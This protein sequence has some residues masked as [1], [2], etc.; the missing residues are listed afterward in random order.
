MVSAASLSNVIF[1]W[2]LRGGSAGGED[3]RLWCTLGVKY[4]HPNVNLLLFYDHVYAW[5]TRILYRLVHSHYLNVVS[6]LIGMAWFGVRTITTTRN[7][8]CVVFWL[9]SCLDSANRRGGRT[10]YQIWA[11]LTREN[12]F[13]N[14]KKQ[15][16]EA[17]FHRCLVPNRTC[18][19]NQVMAGKAVEF[20]YWNG[21]FT[22]VR[23]FN[24]AFPAMT[25][26]CR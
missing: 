23:V 1:Y 20:F 12:V 22:W 4:F 25:S 24:T 13:L 8:L 10:V 17:S 7:T 3:W 26:R 9:P 2:R 18:W 15:K 19:G 21:K 5:Y 14:P 6:K 16:W 11:L